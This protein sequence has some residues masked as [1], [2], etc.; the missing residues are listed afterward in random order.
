LDYNKCLWVYGA[1]SKSTKHSKKS[2]LPWITPH[3]STPVEERKL[4]NS[5]K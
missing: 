1:A 3:S 4:R 5:V 2:I